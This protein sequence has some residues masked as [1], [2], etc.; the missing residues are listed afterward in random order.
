MQT[1][2]NSVGVIMTDQLRDILIHIL[3][4][5]PSPDIRGTDILQGRV[6][7]SFHAPVT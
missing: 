2:N 7:A 4:D 6:T 3:S 5:D 1:S